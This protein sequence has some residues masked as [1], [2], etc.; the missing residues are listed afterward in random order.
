MKYLRIHIDRIEEESLYGHTNAVEECRISLHSPEG[1]DHRYII[2]LLQPG[3]QVNIGDYKII[4]DI[5]HPRFIILEPD[6]LVDVSA[7]AA[8][9]ESYGNTHLTHLIRAFAEEQVPSVSGY[10][11]LAAVH[12]RLH[13]GS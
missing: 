9:C 2:S 7:I 13:R 4:E 12:P 1:G 5:Y 11:L 8:C 3:S 6:Y 10:G